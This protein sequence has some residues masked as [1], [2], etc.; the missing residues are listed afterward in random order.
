MGEITLLG[1]AIYRRRGRIGWSLWY[2]FMFFMCAIFQPSMLE[3][4]LPVPDRYVVQG[5]GL[6]LTPWLN[7]I[8]HIEFQFIDTKLNR[9]A[10][11][12]YSHGFGPLR[13]D[14][15]F[16]YTHDIRLDE[17]E[18]TASWCV[19]HEIGHHIDRERGMISDS[20]RFQYL[21]NRSIT[22][23]YEQSPSDA[24]HWW[25]TGKQIVEFPGVNGNPL[26]ENGWGGYGELYAR[27]HEVD[28]LIQ[29]P[30]PLQEYFVDYIDWTWHNR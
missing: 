11:C 26:N 2:A 10:S 7:H 21:V 23:F 8:E 29:V 24:R 27:L 25:N 5:T 1:D 12:A 6:R 16:I 13:T 3:K 4:R 9:P 15:I 20:K 19:K 18:W 17:W 22:M 30:P 14:K 28:W